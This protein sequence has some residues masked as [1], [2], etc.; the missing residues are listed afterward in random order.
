VAILGVIGQLHRKLLA[1][2]GMPTTALG[3]LAV[4]LHL[5][6]YMGLF[7]SREINL[8]TFNGCGR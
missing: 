4:V 3:T 1:L 5:A 2:L 7:F 6:L 8:S